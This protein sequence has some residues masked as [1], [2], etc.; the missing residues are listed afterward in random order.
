VDG[1][2]V[3]PDRL[4]QQGGGA[5]PVVPK[6]SEWPE[7]KLALDISFTAMNVDPNVR[8]PSE[9]RVKLGK[10]AHFA[11]YE[12][13]VKID[14]LIHAQLDLATKDPASA[15]KAISTVKLLAM[16]A[17]TF[18]RTQAIKWRA[19]GLEHDHDVEKLPEIH[20]VDYSPS[21]LA[22]LRLRAEDS[23]DPFS[24]SYGDEPTTDVGLEGGEGGPIDD[25]D[26]VSLC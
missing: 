15:H 5:S 18:E 6:Q 4:A 23:I 25:S 7:I 3:A 13:A 11:A 14:T 21:E 10:E 19:L 8:V 16:A 2:G 12:G 9:G 26:I 17:Q 22:E 1:R 20:I 24:V